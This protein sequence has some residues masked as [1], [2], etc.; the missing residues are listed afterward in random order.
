MFDLFDRATTL[1]AATW[2]DMLTPSARVLVVCWD[3]TPI[4]AGMVQSY[5]YDRD[6]R[7]VTVEHAEIRELFKHRLTFG[8]IDE[9]AYQAGDLVVENQTLASIVRAVLERALGGGPNWLLPLILPA[10]QAG[11]FS[12][13]W[14]R[15]ETPTIDDCLSDVEEMGTEVDFHPEYDAQM[16]LSWRVRVGGPYLAGISDFHLQ[17]PDSPISAVSVT[18]DGRK[19]LTGAFATGNGTGED[20]K[21]GI[22][23]GGAAVGV[24]PTR[25]MVVAGGA[26]RSPGNL[27]QVASAALSEY[28]LPTNQWSF[29]VHISEETPPTWTPSRRIRLLSA[30][31]LFIPDGEV[32]LR[33]ISVSGDMGNTLK[34]EVHTL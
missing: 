8:V 23:P 32:M 19:Q 21:V 14:R 3:S 11:T 30:G 2:E 13:V 5:T 4:Y 15:Y 6:A 25:D 24:I 34:P 1:D 17:A 12:K 29:Q 10:F 20:L 7:S 33:I 22:A 28:E 31:D 18:V 9:A 16:N 26:E 27:A